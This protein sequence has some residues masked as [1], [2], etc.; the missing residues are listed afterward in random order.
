MIPL[1]HRPRKRFGQNFLH[2][3]SVLVRM[4]R[5]INPQPGDAIVEIGPGEGAL[6]CPLLKAH[7]KLTAIELDRDLIPPLEDKC[8]NLGTF[9]LLRGD[10]VKFDFST[11]VSGDNKLRIVGNL[12]YNISV[13]ML[14]HLAEHAVII[15]DMHVL[16]QREVAYRIAAQ[17]GGGHY[18]RLS[19][20]MQTI[21]DVALL[22]DIGP[23][24]FRPPP[25]V[26]STFVRLMPHAAPIIDIPSTEALATVVTAAFSRRRKTLRN[27]LKQLF[28]STRIKSAG[29]DPSRRAETLSL[30]EFASLARVLESDLSSSH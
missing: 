25:R 19:V 23:G 15:R 18:G 5:T 27:G 17:P 12:P 9:T 10:A 26:H 14:F 16:L 21:F 1:N 29:I 24:A 2:D 3:Q 22:F 20:M 30:E 6:T 7:G 28:D 4:M 8:R 11:L 13:P